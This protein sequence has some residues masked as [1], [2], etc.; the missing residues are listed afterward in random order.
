M[1]FFAQSGNVQGRNSIVYYANA[2]ECNTE[3]VKKL[4]CAD[5][6]Y[7][8]DDPEGAETSFHG[9]ENDYP[10][11]IEKIL[12]GELLK[13]K[14]YY[15]LILTMIDFHARNASYENLTDEE[16]YKAFE[17]VSKGLMKEVFKDCDGCH[18]D[19][20]KSLDFMAENWGFQPVCSPKEELFSSD[21][22]TLLFSVNDQ[23][24]FLFLP[25]NP[26]Y[27]IVAVDKRKIRITGNKINDEDNGMLNAYQAYQCIEFVYSNID[28]S[29][30]IGEDK[31]L[32]KWLNKPKP[33]GF[34]KNDS[35]L[36]EFIEYPNNM[37]SE[38]SFI[39]VIK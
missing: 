3:K 34:V 26:H 9:M 10:N 13:T 6:H 25:I 7:S 20:Q 24:A 8:E 35:W 32:T 4:S 12:A 30:Y 16:N 2:T 36:P 23:L 33:R 19:M 11:I 21:H 1:K 29:T 38:F 5:F 27:G 17:I 37:P 14:E 15:G 22:P 31:P 18:N 28:L 39:E